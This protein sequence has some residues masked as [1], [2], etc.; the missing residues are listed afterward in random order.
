M[1]DHPYMRWYK[2]NHEQNPDPVNH[3]STTDYSSLGVIGNLT[4]ALDR[5]QQTYGSR[6]RFPIY[7]T[8]FGYI[9]SPPAAARPDLSV[10]VIY[11]FSQGGR[12]GRRVPG[13]SATALRWIDSTCCTTGEADRSKTSAGS[14]AG[15]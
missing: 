12:H 14:P 7:D 2:P 3:S 15:C 9:T 11:L 13:F 10:K 8:E 6:T 1:T 5:L 4:R